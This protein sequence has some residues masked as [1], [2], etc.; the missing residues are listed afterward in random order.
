M[1]DDIRLLFR[2]GIGLD[3]YIKTDKYNLSFYHIE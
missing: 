1:C 2:T 3:I